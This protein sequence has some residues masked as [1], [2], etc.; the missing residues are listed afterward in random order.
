MGGFSIPVIIGSTRRGRQT[1]RAARFVHGRLKSRDP[2]ESA[3]LDLRE[4]DFPIMEERLRRRDDPPPGLAGFS[5][6]IADGDAL[7]IVSPEYNSG[8][9]GVLK[10]ALDYLLPEY[11]RKPV[12][13][14]TVSAGSLGGAS[15]LAQ[16]RQV[17]LSLGALPIP[18]KLPVTRVGS[19]FGEDGEP[20]DPAY[21]KRADTFID[22]LLWYTEALSTQRA[23]DER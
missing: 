11:R 2:V 1:P 20:T 13:I 7:V 22:E 18:A 21:E 10:N 4:Y 6:H 8:Y 19:S 5:R 17:I 23:G 16:L 15:C 14:V 12:G 3:L 9:P